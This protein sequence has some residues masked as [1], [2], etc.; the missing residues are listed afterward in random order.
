MNSRFNLI[1]SLQ[2]TLKAAK[3]HDVRSAD[4]SPG[5]PSVD[6]KK[7]EEVDDKQ[8]DI[9]DISPSS[10]RLNAKAIVRRSLERCYGKKRKEGMSGQKQDNV[11]KNDPKA[12][13]K[14][15][16]VENNDCENNDMNDTDNSNKSDSQVK[17]FQ[18]HRRAFSQG[19]LN[20]PP[21][22]W[23]RKSVDVDKS[24]VDGLVR[25]SS[26]GDVRNQD[27]GDESGIQSDTV[28][29]EATTVAQQDMGMEGYSPR[30]DGKQKGDGR[31][32]KAKF[33]TK[34]AD[35]FAKLQLRLS[36]NKT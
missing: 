6:V 34:A 13:S 26:T 8:V 20:I 7:D 25:R 5:R 17:K 32:K 35:L 24:Q 15:K 9:D 36:T 2:E 4:S 27:E 29:S 18:A 31:G 10:T 1:Y 3:S 28:T 23:E 14:N 19:G 30:L 11:S 33:G 12:D 22:P 21:P 16:D